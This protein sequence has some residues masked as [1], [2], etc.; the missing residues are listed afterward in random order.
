MEE[1]LLERG[2]VVSYETTRRWSLKFGAAYARSLR[3]RK[4]RPS[5]LRH[6]DAVRIVIRGKPHWLWRVV[7]QDGY[8][9]DEIL[10]SSETQTWS[11]DPV[12][13]A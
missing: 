6:L 4:A 7:D 3:C 8:V 10:W 2:I 12:S 9:L 5:D 11:L 1:M 13:L